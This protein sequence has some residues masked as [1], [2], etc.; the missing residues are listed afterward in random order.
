MIR[1]LWMLIERE[2][3]RERESREARGFQPLAAAAWSTGG[4][5]GGIAAAW[6]TGGHLPPFPPLVTEQSNSL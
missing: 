4:H 5:L 3:Q 1:G 2:R 6:S